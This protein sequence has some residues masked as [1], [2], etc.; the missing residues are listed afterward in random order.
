MA[1]FFLNNA[2]VR[3]SL[4]PISRLPSPPSHQLDADGTPATTFD[5]V[6]P[7]VDEAYRG[8]PP[9]IPGLIEAEEYD[10]GGEGV[11]YSDSDDSNIGGVSFH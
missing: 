10:L 4:Y 1:L 5:E 6:I 9:Q 7:T 8:N 3:L 2:Y 11:G